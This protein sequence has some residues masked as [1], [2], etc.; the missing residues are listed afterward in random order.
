M[1]GAPEFNDYHHDCAQMARFYGLPCYSTAGVGDTDVPGIQ[2]TAEKMLTFMSVPWSGAQY[3]HYAF[4]LLERTNM[5][6]PEQ[7]VMDD[8]HIGIV[9]WTFSA[10][11]ISEERRED[12]LTMVR[13]V[14]DTD[15][16]TYMYHL[17]LP[18]HEPVYV[19]YPLEDDEDGALL[20]A[21]RRYH[22]IMGL[23]RNPL[24]KEMQEEITSNVPGVLP[25]A[26]DV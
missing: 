19:R 1:Y 21:H 6:C 26:L 17:P 24:P 3:I 22:E 5:F 16:K 13:E 7:A 8:A 9:K 15:H 25:G 18:T 20:A 14:M 10:P 12:V 4:G 23:P 2:A 11:D